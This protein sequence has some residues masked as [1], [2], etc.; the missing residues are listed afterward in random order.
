[1]KYTTKITDIK[2]DGVSIYGTSLLSLMSELSFGD[3]IFFLLKG[4]K[5]TTS[6]ST[7]FNALLVAAIDH[8]PGTASA[9]T[10]R[11]V[12]SAKNSMHVSIASGIL[13]MGELHGSSIE[14]AA[15]FFLEAKDNGD[16]NQLVQDYKSDKKRIPGFGHAVLTVD[17]R[18]DELLNIAKDND[19][20]G[21]YCDIAIKTKDA[22][23]AI[24][25]KVLPLNID[26]A[27]AAILLDLDF[28]PDVMK[29]IFAIA[30]L[31]GLVAQVQEEQHDGNGLRRVKQEH[32]EYI[33][34]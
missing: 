17:H 21:I 5:P 12:A 25:S 11:I 13:A 33:G 10:A 22:L 7:V 16:I 4:T 28:K 27:M 6:Q 30:R 1:M 19:C 15:N 32:I 24:S 20:F 2:N 8:G 18:A 29:G 3:A 26:G 31:P 14:Y 34:E 9:Q 23:N